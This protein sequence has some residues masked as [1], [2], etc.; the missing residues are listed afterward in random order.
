[1]S[2]HRRVTDEYDIIYDFEDSRIFEELNECEDEEDA[3]EH[4]RGTIV[5]GK[6][7]YPDCQG[8]MIYVGN[9]CFV[10]SMCGRS[11]HEDIYYRWAAG[12]TIEFED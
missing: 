7:I 4:L 10:C 2:E 3:I 8:E 1:M 11:V 9:I 6:C 5:K 12:Y